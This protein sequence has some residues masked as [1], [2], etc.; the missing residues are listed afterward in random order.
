MTRLA[1]DLGTSNTV[2][3]RWNDREACGET[4]RIEALSAPPLDGQPPVIPSALWIENAAEAQCLVGMLAMQREQT[5]LPSP[6]FVRHFKRN[7]MSD[8]PG[9]TP[10]LDGVEITPQW[11]GQQFL[12]TT[13]AAVKASGQ[14]VDEVILTVPVNAFETYSQWLAAHSQ[15]ELGCSVRLLDESTAA[16][17]G[18]A[19]TCPEQPVLVID[20]GGGTLDISLVR[21]PR[22]LD[23][24]TARARVL[25]K[26]AAWLGGVDIDQWLLD[27]FLVAHGASS[28][29][30]ADDLNRLKHLAERVKIQLS[31]LRQA[32]FVY[33]DTTQSRVWSKTY[34][35]D[36]LDEL[37]E[38]NDFFVRMQSALDQV[39]RQAESHGLTRHDIAHV[40]LVGGSTLIP[41]VGRFFRQN[42]PRDRVQSHKPFEAVAH[43]ALLL[44]HQVPVD[45]FLHHGYGIRYW[46]PQKRQHEYEPLYAPGTRYPTTTPISLT[47]RA[48][49]PRQRAIELII[50][51]MEVA[52]PAPAEVV[53]TQGALVSHPL[54]QTP[55]RVVPLNAGD[56][57]K[58][59]AILEPPGFP[60]TDR[61]QIEFFID[62]NRQLRLSVRDLLSDRLL[63][64]QQAV[65]QLR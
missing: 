36:D 41:A 65:V 14:E 59:V 4:L 23:A 6:R 49:R 18:Y 1:V 34:T 56:G 15:A 20:F 57:A 32:D 11:V 46:N 37:L 21:L 31:T 28:V 8:V 52:P 25:A 51:E 16:A 13:F 19:L 35:R 38:K 44:G 17:L 5:S 3:A 29:T 22:V 53:F 10:T 54:A 7:L 63:L 27:D 42:F 60:G 61:L 26:A 43:G 47:L 9:F 62:A 39:L 12:R 45:D 55:L 2:V 30:H 24:G 48:S 40:L 58:T 50:G 64:E 33:F